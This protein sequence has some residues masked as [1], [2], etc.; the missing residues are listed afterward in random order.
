MAPVSR[1][2]DTKR[3]ARYGLRRLDDFEPLN[4]RRQSEYFRYLQDGDSVPAQSDPFFSGSILPQRHLPRDRL[5]EWYAEM[6]TRRRLLDLAAARWFVLPG[7][8]PRSQRDAARAFVEA[9]GLV[10]REFADPHVGLYENPRALPRAYVTYRA[11][12]APDTATLLE[13]LSRDDFDPLVLS[14]V[15]GEPGFV[16]AA[17]APARGGPARVTRDEETVI[18][19]EAELAAPGLL[20]LADSYAAGWRAQVDGAPASVRAANF[21]FRGVPVPAGRHRVRFE[22]RP[23]SVTAGAA[24]S[25]GGGALLAGLALFARRRNRARAERGG[26]SSGGLSGR[27]ASA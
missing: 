9:A 26:R 23:R 12:P 22:Y 8:L 5:V 4:L 27:S 16:A 7:A 18:E 24:A 3:A 15:E 6:A 11:A 25:L 10:R 14:Y 1:R 21:L 20:V 13:R 19:V 2:S 17:S